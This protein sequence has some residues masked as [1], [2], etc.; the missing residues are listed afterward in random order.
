MLILLITENGSINNVL[1]K[2]AHVIWIKDVSKAMSLI[3]SEEYDDIL[4]SEPFNKNKE[5]LDFLDSKNLKYVLLNEVDDLKKYVLDKKAQKNQQNEEQ[6]ANTDNVEKKTYS[7]E[8]VLLVTTNQ[9]TIQ[10]LRR[11]NLTIATTPFSASQRIQEKTYRA[12]VWD[13]P[14]EPVKTPGLLYVWGR[15][16]K[17]PEELDFVL[18][19]GYLKVSNTNHTPEPTTKVVLVPETKHKEEEEYSPEINVEP[20]KNEL[21]VLQRL[22]RPVENIENTGIAKPQKKA[23]LPLKKSK[24]ETNIEQQKVSSLPE[25]H[26]L[27]KVRASIFTKTGVIVNN[28]FIKVKFDNPNEIDFE[29]DAL[30]ITSSMGLS[31]VKEYRRQNPLRPVVVLGGD[32]SFLDVGADK[33]VKRINK[34]VIEEMTHL[35]ERI[36]KLWMQMETDS[37]TGVYT[38]AFF[39]KWKED[40]ESRGK[41]YSIVL[42]DIDKFKAVNDTYGH[43]AGDLVLHQFAQFLKNSV[44]AQ[45]LVVRWGGEE[46]IV[47]LPDTNVKQ[48]YVVIDRLREIWSRRAI[49]MPNGEIY[50]GTFSA[51]VAQYKGPGHDAI[52]EADELLYMAKNSGRNKVLPVTS[53]KIAILGNIPAVQFLEKGYQIMTDYR[54]ADCIVADINAVMSFSAD[55][56]PPGITLYILGKGKPSDLK[57]KRLF[58][59]AFLYKDIESIISAIEGDPVKVNIQKAEMPEKPA[60]LAP[61]A[62]PNITVLP[63]VRANKNNLTIPKGGVIFVVCPSRPGIA[64]ELAA[65]LASAIDNTA[66]VCAAP[67]SSAALNL[68]VNPMTLIEADW[69]FP[70]SIAPIQHSGIYIWPVDPY[71]YTGSVTPYDVHRLVEQIK[72]KFN[73]VIVDCCGSLSYCSRVAH[74]EA[75]MVI[76][77]EG[78]SSDAVTEQWLTNYK[79]QNVLEVSPIQTPSITEVGNGLLINT[80]ALNYKEQYN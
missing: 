8:S 41:G 75:I 43:D 3:D 4:V 29:Y 52:K 27:P 31:C 47:A 56:I 30:V 1:S 67:E 19:N 51:G 63:G 65:K 17:N 7:Q 18:R 34:Q 24:T 16:L 22:K 35:N 79:G 15:D 70:R 48:S 2:M 64:S 68:G 40:R 61:V 36:K 26:N 42:I 50:K 23:L 37:L 39:E 25:K 33:C 6:P 14:A 66:L 21:N 12:V 45:D 13:L 55:I 10:E 80:K 32:K 54:E 58:P 44:R 78:D 5:L 59:S 57:V 11:F 49:S 73:L 60:E 72:H 46:F 62:K 53:S 77:K 76:K 20:I 74:D 69:R 71:K 28:R 9:K 38:R